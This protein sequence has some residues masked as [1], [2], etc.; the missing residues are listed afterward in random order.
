MRLQRGRPRDHGEGSR[1]IQA[2]IQSPI[3]SFPRKRESSVFWANATGSPLS[4]GRRKLYEPG[5]LFTDETGQLVYRLVRLW[6]NLDRQKYRR[7]EGLDHPPYDPVR[8]LG[9]DLRHHVLVG[10]HL[11][12]LALEGEIARVACDLVR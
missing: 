11:A 9:S 5:T 4:R 10:D 12:E 1:N 7:R 6:A 2:G 3:S 8:S